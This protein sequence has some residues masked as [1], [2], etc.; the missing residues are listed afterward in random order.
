MQ[1]HGP[2]RKEGLHFCDEKIPF[3]EKGAHLKLVTF[4]LPALWCQDEHQRSVDGEEG[5]VGGVPEHHQEGSRR[6]A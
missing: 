2:V 6:K 3:F 1:G 4:E 5:K